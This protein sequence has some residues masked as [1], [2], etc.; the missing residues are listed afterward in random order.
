MLES[1]GHSY[2]ERHD[3]SGPHPAD[4]HRSREQGHPGSGRVG[5]RRPHGED[6]G[7]GGAAAR[8]DPRPESRR[9]GPRA[10]SRRPVEHPRPLRPRRSGQWRQQGDPRGRANG[11]LRP[12]RAS[13]PSRRDGCC[14]PPHDRLAATVVAGLA[15]APPPPC[16]RKG[17]DYV[18]SALHSR[19]C[20]ACPCLP[21]RAPAMG[22]TTCAGASLA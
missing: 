21:A 3:L 19:S 9:R 8:S 14:G 20:R 1:C 17:C 15:P 13:R 22:A 11:P 5:V 4:R 12:C 18:A 10:R 7:E 6:T 16:N 2:L